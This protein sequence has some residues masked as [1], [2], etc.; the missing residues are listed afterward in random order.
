MLSARLPGLLPNMSP[1]EAL[2]TSIIKSLSGAIN[3]GGI[4]RSRPFREP[5]HTASMA[6]LI[7]GGRHAKL[8]EISLAHNGVLFLDEFPEFPRFVLDALRQ[9]I[10]TG[11]VIISRANAHIK[12]PCKFLLLA[13]ANPC[14]CGY[15]S[16]PDRACSRAP[17]CGQD[18]MG[19]ISGPLMDRFDIRI[20]VPA[21]AFQDLDAP[22]LGE[23]TQKIA[24]LVL[25][26]REM[27]A[28]CI[29]LARPEKDFLVQVAEKFKFS[30]RAFH[31]ILRVS[32]TI[33]DL[34]GSSDIERPH[35]A[36]ALSFRL[37]TAVES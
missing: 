36:E 1:L 12:Y 15:L 5:H 27:Q 18:Y 10:E 37:M 16:D 11:E 26:A 31:R 13:A 14:K 9:P 20:E 8:G 19:R 29:T 34:D 4:E 28:T 2:E 32:R 25:T 23:R 6:A 24:E 17:L 35:L 7:G 22:A 3:K 21:V 30:A 33:A